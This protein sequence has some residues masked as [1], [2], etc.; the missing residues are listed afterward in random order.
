MSPKEIVKAFYDSDLANDED[1]IPRFFHKDCELHWNS[2]QGFMLL[3]YDDIV[4][5]FKGTRDSYNNLRFECSHLL[6]DKEFVTSRHTLYAHTIE[7]PDNE[8]ALAHFL[9]IWELK[10][11]KLFRC[12]EI[13]QL[14]DEKTLE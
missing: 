2:S 4:T 13:S 5:F 10:D 7:D 12:Y 14:Y 6:E 1:V 8:I 11:E 3:K 9:A